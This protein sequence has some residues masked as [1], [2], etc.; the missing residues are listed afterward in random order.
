MQGKEKKERFGKNR[1]R[2]QPQG[3]VQASTFG[4]KNLASE[5]KGSEEGREP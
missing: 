4:K 5:V 1:R 3:L 2:K